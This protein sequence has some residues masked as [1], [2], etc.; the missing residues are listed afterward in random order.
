MQHSSGP[1]ASSTGQSSWP[2]WA[3]TG[4]VRCSGPVLWRRASRWASGRRE[5][6]WGQA[7]GLARPHCLPPSQQKENLN[8]MDPS[9]PEVRWNVLRAS[10][11][12][13]SLSSMSELRQPFLQLQWVCAQSCPT[14]CNPMDCRHLSHAQHVP[15][16][17]LVLNMSHL[18]QMVPFNNHNEVCIITQTRKQRLFYKQGNRDSQ[19]L[20]VIR[21]RSKNK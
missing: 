15:G 2:G 6:C 8:P 13:L 11:N 14:L 10:P 21:L 4:T 17:S 1:R 16:T 7:A 20:K 19:K 9:T 12:H 5:E 3:S 18:E